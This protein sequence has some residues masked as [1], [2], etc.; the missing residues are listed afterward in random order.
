MLKIR[1]PWGE[2]EWKGTASDRDKEFWG[3]ISKADQDRLGY[4]NKDDGVF[5]ML[6]EDFDQFFVVVDLCH[7]NDCANYFYKE[8]NFQSG[9]P[10]YIDFSTNGGDLTFALS[11]VSGRCRKVKGS[12]EILDNLVL[13]LG[14][15][16]G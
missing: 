7:I 10:Q 13:I 6:W 11:Q 9:R 8:L 3:S 1:N 4:T 5:F 12:S 15:K 16:T 2:M 14:K